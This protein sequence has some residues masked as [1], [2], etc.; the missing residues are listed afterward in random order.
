MNSI[1]LSGEDVFDDDIE[2]HLPLTGALPASSRSNALSNKLTSVLSSSYADPEI[3]TALGLLDAKGVKNGVE[4][5]RE[6]RL[7]A[8]KQVVDCNV[9]VVRD[10][11]KVAEV[12]WG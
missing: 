3:R 12:R 1:P 6:L 4:T 7:E 9:Q 10:F 8:Q 5:R 11:G 2:P